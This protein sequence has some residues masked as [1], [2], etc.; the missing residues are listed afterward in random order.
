ML[1]FFK[2]QT[3]NF[4]SSRYFFFPFSTL[5]IFFFSL[6]FAVLLF[7]YLLHKIGIFQCIGRSLCKMLW[8]CFTSCFYS[9]E[10]GCM[11]LWFKLK[12]LK[13]VNREQVRD[14]EG[15]LSS[16]SE[17][18][19]EEDRISYRHVPRSSKF[20]RSLSHRTRERRRIQLERSLRPRSHRIRVGI[21]QSSVYV[22][23]R[24]ARKHDR[25]VSA[26]HHNVKVTRTSKFVQKGN[27][28]KIHHRRW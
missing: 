9:C 28:N 10:Y 14:V 20:R 25:H 18:D 26:V 1:V 21:S 13:Q 16:S 15:Y 2:V 8:A 12:N 17:D 6:L 5:A 7:F 19:L 23:E 22:N 3:A 11:F 4:T 24:E 27:V